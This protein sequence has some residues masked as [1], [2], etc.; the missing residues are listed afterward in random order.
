[1]SFQSQVSAEFKEIA[2]TMES[3][4][5]RSGVKVE[6][7]LLADAIYWQDEIPQALP[8]F[9]ENCLRCVLHFR[10]SLLLESPEVRW[11]MYWDEAQNHFPRWIGFNHERVTPS[12]S[13]K[14]Q[15]AA[16]RHESRH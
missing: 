2:S 7:H 14:N 12:I 5:K 11:R 1:M 16:F 10:T 15:I 3:L 8:R 6:Y 13:L 4:K 9:A